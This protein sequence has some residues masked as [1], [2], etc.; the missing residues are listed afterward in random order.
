MYMVPL[1]CL[2][3]VLRA[4][5][6]C[7]SICVSIH[8]RTSAYGQRVA[9]PAACGPV[10]P[11]LHVLQHLPHVAHSKAGVARVAAPAAH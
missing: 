1:N 9:A 10:R 3:C 7:C 5:P 4:L 6:S 11:V 8:R 2:S